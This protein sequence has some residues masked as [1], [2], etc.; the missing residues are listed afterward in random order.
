MLCG[1]LCNRVVRYIEQQQL[2]NSN[3]AAPSTGTVTPVTSSAP[4]RPFGPPA[5]KLSGTHRTGTD[6]L[7]EC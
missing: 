7:L 5:E 4:E 2:V 3:V 1:G 6:T